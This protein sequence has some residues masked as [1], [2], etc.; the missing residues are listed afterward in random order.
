MDLSEPLNQQYVYMVI[1]EYFAGEVQYAR[2]GN[3]AEVCGAL[4]A[5]QDAPLDTLAQLVRDGYGPACLVAEYQKVLD[6]Y[7]NATAFDSDI[8][9][10]GVVGSF[11]FI[12]F[13][14]C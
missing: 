14:L 12:I 10:Y 3:L 2:S 4:A 6:Y 1:A 7:N 9:K 13:F 11:F 5:G 8:S